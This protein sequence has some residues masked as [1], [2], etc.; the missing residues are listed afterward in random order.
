M[1][2]RALIISDVIL[3]FFSSFCAQTATFTCGHQHR[4]RCVFTYTNSRRKCFDVVMCLRT[5]RHLIACQEQPVKRNFIRICLNDN[6]L[7]THSYDFTL[8]TMFLRPSIYP[9]TCKHLKLRQ[10]L[11]RLIGLIAWMTCFIRYMQNMC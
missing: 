4:H 5:V 9:F 10:I 6:H 11:E 1:D 7:T 8:A 2:Y 3:F